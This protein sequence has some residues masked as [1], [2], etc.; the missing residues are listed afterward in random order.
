MTIHSEVK[1]AKPAKPVM[2]L[3]RFIRTPKGLLLIILGGL[4]VLASLG[5][6]L[7]QVAPSLASAVLVA[8]LLDM[9]ILRYRRSRW[10]FPSGAILTGLIIAMVLSLGQP[11]YVAGCTSAVAIV[12]KYVFRTKSANV[13]NPAAF[14]IVATFYV[15]GTIQSWWGAL[16]EVTPAAMVVLFA[17]GIFIADRVNKLPLVLSFLGSFYLLF[18]LTAFFQEPGTVEEIFRPPEVQMALYF[19][20]FILTDP[21]TSPAK[22]RDQLIFGALVAVVS[23]GVCQ[24][25]RPAP[26]YLLAGVL[27][28]N[29]WEAWRRV[30]QVKRRAHGNKR[31]TQ[32]HSGNAIQAASPHA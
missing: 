15:F 28:A 2:P 31:H 22:H 5:E 20:F 11:W 12:S 17:T 18:T 8:A 19:A 30:R 14:A 6:G 4:T 24:W 21:P 23:Y 32:I 29:V 27:A 7:R 25:V 13:F 1:R 26:Y 16:S 10:E 9:P 3:R